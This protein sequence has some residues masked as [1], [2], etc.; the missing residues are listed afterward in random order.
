MTEVLTKQ[1][2]SPEAPRTEL[3]FPPGRTIFPYSTQIGWEVDKKAGVTLLATTCGNKRSGLTVYTA[4]NQVI[5]RRG[6]ECRTLAP[7]SIFYASK[8]DALKPL[9][10]ALIR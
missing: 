7:G 9:K 5:I 3:R 4:K 6:R 1:P 10:N 2:P 8:S